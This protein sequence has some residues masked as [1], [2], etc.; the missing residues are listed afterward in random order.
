MVYIA[1][2]LLH[3]EIQMTR[4]QDLFQV[5]TVVGQPMTVGDITV[6]PQSQVLIVRLPIGGFVWNRPTA[7]VVER[8]G[9]AKRVSVR[10][11]TRIL[12]LGLLSLGLLLSLV[13]LITFSQRKESDHDR[14]QK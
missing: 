13:K 6:T 3:E 1:R 2:E 12:Q 9:Q 4:L 14:H 5:Q 7:I 8:E 11:I 10:D